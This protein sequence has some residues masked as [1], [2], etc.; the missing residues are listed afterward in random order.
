MQ[1]KTTHDHLPASQEHSMQNNT[2]SSPSL[3]GAQH[4]FASSTSPHI[5]TALPSSVFVKADEGRGTQTQA[6]FQREAETGRL[7]EDGPLTPALAPTGTRDPIAFG[8]SRECEG[9]KS[10]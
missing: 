2:R 5:K 7:C 3:T 9:R 8:E 1:N 6:S 10:L 4:A